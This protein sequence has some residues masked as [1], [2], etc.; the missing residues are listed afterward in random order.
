[1]KKVLSLLMILVMVFSLFTGCNNASSENQVSNEVD[2]K[3]EKTEDEKTDKEDEI[4]S[5]EKVEL[6][7][8]MSFPRFKDHFEAYF[9]KFKAKMLAEENIEV[10]IELEMPAADQAG[11]ILQARLASND[12]PDIFTLHAIAD[13]P[14]FYEAGYLSDLS[15]LEFTDTVYN[16]VKE[17]V[18]YDGK[19]VALPLESLAWGYLYNQ[20][21][22]NEYGLTPPQTIEEMEKVVET[23]TSN[24]ETPFLLSFQE[25][26]IP[27]LMMA[28]S[29]GGTVTAE[30]PD[31]IE[32][33]NAGTG[34]Y[35]DVASVFDIIDI[36]MA[37]GSENPFEIGSAA[38]SADFANG[39]AAM[40]VQGPWMSETIL[41]VNPDMKIGVAPLPVSDNPDAAMI[42]LSTSTSLA[43]S[44]TS[45]NQ[46][47]AAKLL[48]FIL[49]ADESSALFDS[50]KFNPISSV[51]SYESFPWVDEAMAYVADGKAYRDLSLPGG[52]TDETAQLLQAYYA[53]SVTK[54]EFLK[55]LDNAWAAALKAQ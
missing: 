14:K 46:D 1:M 50:L 15:N 41:K 55:T 27:Q 51:H 42:N 24:D 22:F 34:S 45:K 19:V 8:F 49:D 48:N 18:S 23:L 5:P 13:I 21:I 4:K 30:H 9:E 54:D 17:M 40:W 6:K 26:W 28:L 33:M 44:P 31:F 35:N 53:N 12:A 10:T 2:Q 36:I 37:N 32:N 52:V 39:K 25:S 3:V 11:Q 16:S 29:L 20:D 43:I 38:G 47:V 7:V